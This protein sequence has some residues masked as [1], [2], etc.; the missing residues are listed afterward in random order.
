MYKKM[1]EYEECLK[2][3]KLNPYRLEIVPAKHLDTNMCMTALEAMNK[4]EKYRDIRWLAHHILETAWTDELV[5]SLLEATTYENVLDYIPKKFYTYERCMKAVEYSKGSS[6]SHVPDELKTY[7]MCLVAVKLSEGEAMMDVPER[8]LTGELCVLALV[9]A[10]YLEPFEDCLAWTPEELLTEE[11]YQN[12]FKSSLIKE[13]DI[14][15][16]MNRYTYRTNQPVKLFK[17]SSN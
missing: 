13:E 3:V 9:S 12:V 7:E 1:S 8:Y 10:K 15:E 11:F 2:L 6:L 5:D 16:F 17:Y 14:V 4:Y